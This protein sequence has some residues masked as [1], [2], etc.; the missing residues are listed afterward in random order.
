MADVLDGEEGAA[1]LYPPTV[2]PPP[3]PLS[4]PMYLITFIGNPLRVMPRAVYHEPIVQYGKRL[5]W[6]TDPRLVKRVLL[7]DCDDFP[8]THVEGRV[9]GGLLGRGILIA[10]GRDWR[11]QR[12]TAAPEFRHADI[13]QY[14][15]TMVEAA[16]GLVAEW[17]AAAPGSIHAIDDDMTRVTFRVIAETMLRGG[18]VA[19]SDGLERSSQ[20]YLGPISWPLLYAV[21]GMP[22]WL[23]FPGRASR[24]RAEKR[25]REAVE[26]IV[27]ARRQNLTERDDLL[28]R[29]LQAKNPDSAQP[30]S[31]VQV[32]DNLLT[33][34]LAGHETTARELTWALYLIARAPAWQERIHKEVVR[35]ADERAI[36]PEHIGKLT[37]TTKVVKETMRLYPPISSLTRVVRRDLEL[38]G[39]Q[40]VA[41]SLV[42]LPMF[43][44]HRH[45]LLWDDPDRFDPERFAP[46]REA[47]H[48]RYQFMPFGAGPRMCIG[49]S[50]SI[51]EAVAMLAT[52][53]RAARFE[54]PGGH[55]PV[56]V[57]GVTLRPKGGMPLSIWLRDR[58]VPSNCRAVTP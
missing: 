26:R 27:Q 28:A 42:I 21:L 25:M 9:L 54:V 34:L 19:E 4:L 14:A 36:A 33:F 32:V 45:R 41:G 53:V 50:F 55:V 11:W 39:K 35:V 15:P 58:A 12:Q 44:M 57:S 10:E 51:I 6:V 49:A 43:A 52:F 29:L 37:D 40:L 18:D 17:R 2:T 13:L 23:P 7:D 8:K 48:A 1:P 38:G 47:A 31:D 22:G 5:T 16:E 46:E 3:A 56:P 30:M 20:A 24:H